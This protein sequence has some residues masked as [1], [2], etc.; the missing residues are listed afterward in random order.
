MT[1]SS[2]SR[3]HRVYLVE[4]RLNV[5][6]AVRVEESLAYDEGRG[7]VEVRPIKEPRQ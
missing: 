2:I 5:T 1:G 6:F 4:R 3:S 7:G